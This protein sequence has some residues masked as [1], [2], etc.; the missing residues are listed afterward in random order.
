MKHNYLKIQDSGQM[1]AKKRGI[2][3]QN[4]EAGVGKICVHVPCLTLDTP[5]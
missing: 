2:D 1:Q 4:K 3:I 5:N